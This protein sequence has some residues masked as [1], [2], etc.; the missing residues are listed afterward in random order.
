MVIES[1]KTESLAEALEIRSELVA[2]KQRAAETSA[3][4]PWFVFAESTFLLHFTSEA[5]A[6]EHS[7]LSS[8]SLHRSRARFLARRLGA[9][10]RNLTAKTCDVATCSEF[11]S[12][13]LGGL[14]GS[15]GCFTCKILRAVAFWILL[16]I[17]ECLEAPRDCT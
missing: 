7:S 8:A 1:E 4:N 17:C 14:S 6:A 3:A 10:L 15:L 9:K 13:W 5:G 11:S 16:A 2:L 12:R